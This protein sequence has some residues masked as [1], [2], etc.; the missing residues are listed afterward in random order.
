LAGGPCSLYRIC[1][2]FL[3]AKWLHH[4]HPGYGYIDLRVFQSGEETDPW[5]RIINDNWSQKYSTF[6]FFPEQDLVVTAL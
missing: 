1:D 2:D 6:H 5:T 4:V 3:I